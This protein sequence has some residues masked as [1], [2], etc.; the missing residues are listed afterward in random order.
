MRCTLMSFQPGGRCPDAFKVTALWTRS[1]RRTT[2]VVHLTIVDNLAAESG[3]TRTR[4]RPPLASFFV[5]SEKYCGLIRSA[6]IHG[7]AHCPSQRHARDRVVFRFKGILTSHC[8]ISVVFLGR[9]VLSQAFNT[10]THRRLPAGLEVKFR[11]KLK[12]SWIVSR[13]HLS[14]C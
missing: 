4:S 13:C 5:V 9:A 3:P 10:P 11:A 12:N 8:L 6:R 7:A 1:P 14:E 2:S